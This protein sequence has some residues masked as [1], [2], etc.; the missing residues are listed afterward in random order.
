M[1]PERGY[2]TVDDGEKRRHNG[3]RQGR[4]GYLRR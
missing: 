1:H 3:T 2:L 4:V